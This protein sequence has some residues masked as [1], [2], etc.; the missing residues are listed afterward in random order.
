MMH[1]LRSLV[2]RQGQLEERMVN[3]RA[4]AE[5]QS[6][7]INEEQDGVRTGANLPAHC[8]VRVGEASRGEEF[9]DSRN[10]GPQ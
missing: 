8:V 2:L 10:V 7:P 9:V 1:T 5:G 6:S 4:R 3:D